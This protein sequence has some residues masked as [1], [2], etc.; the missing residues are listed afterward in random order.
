MTQLFEISKT[1]HFDMT[2][3]LS[4]HQGKCR[5][6]HGHTY[7]LEVYVRG[8]PDKHGFVMD[9]GDL[10]HIVKEEIVDILDH[11]VAIYEKDVTLV[12]ALSGKFRAVMLPFETTAENLCAWIARRLQA[13]NLDISKI[14]LWETPTSKAVL[15]L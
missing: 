6:L 15:T 7:T 4:F 9:F 10:K 2:H 14:I 13:R 3:R 11:S 5:H 12:D 8:V 1:F